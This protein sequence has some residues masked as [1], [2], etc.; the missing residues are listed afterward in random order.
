M[1]DNGC[2]VSL[3]WCFRRRIQWISVVV[4]MFFCYI[5]GA[6]FFFFFHIHDTDSKLLVS[7][8]SINK[9]KTSSRT[10]AL[11]TLLS[12]VFTFMLLE[13]VSVASLASFFLIFF[14]IYLFFP[15]FWRAADKKCCWCVI[16][17]CGGSRGCISRC[18]ASER[19]KGS[20]RE[21]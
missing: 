14:F 21:A 19:V 4:Q 18:L 16:A 13:E 6:F 20:G 17:V 1:S 7:S 12:V 10:D 3:E 8:I 15:F 11:K 5:F 2:V 9:E